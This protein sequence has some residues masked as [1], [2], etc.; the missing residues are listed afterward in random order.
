MRLWHTL[1]MVAALACVLTLTRDPVGRA[2]VIV[3]LTGLGEVGFG[4]AAVLALFQTV[5]ALGEAKGVY[6]HAE[7]LAATT[8]VL[9]LSTALMSGWLFI[10]AWLVSVFV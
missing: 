1:F 4:L 7:A 2:F 6:A 8:V 5:G 3:L 10:G 9:T